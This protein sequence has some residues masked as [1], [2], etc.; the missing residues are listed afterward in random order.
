MG[1][2]GCR[3]RLQIQWKRRFLD[4]LC[5]VPAR[6]PCPICGL[7]WQSRFFLCTGKEAALL[8][9]PTENPHLL[10]PHLPSPHLPCPHLPSPHLP[11]PHLP[12]PHLPSPHLPSPHLPCPHPRQFLWSFRLPGEA[13]KIDR[14]METFAARY[15][16]CNPGVF[17][18]TGADW[19]GTHSDCHTRVCS[20]RHHGHRTP[21]ASLSSQPG[22][23][24][25][26]QTRAEHPLHVTP[27]LG[28]L[29]AELPWDVDLGEVA[30]NDSA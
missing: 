21:H 12:C 17:R 30:G 29:L 13:Q 20:A 10:C 11:S 25:P 7:R 2:S 22:D 15:C 6:P 3:L 19:G 26:P 16:L 28:V 4:I 27:R 1:P 18:S 23:P 5:L 9:G 14:M 24:D 8:S